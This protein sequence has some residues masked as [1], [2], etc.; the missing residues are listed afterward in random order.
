MMYRSQK[1]R[2]LRKSLLEK[3]DYICQVCFKKKQKMTIHHIKHAL[4]YPDLFYEPSNLLVVCNNCHKQKFHRTK[5][6]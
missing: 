4:D 5:K 3:H 2:K 6:K 1:Y